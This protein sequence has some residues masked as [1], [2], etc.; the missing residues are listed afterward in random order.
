[1]K[2]KVQERA[3]TAIQLVFIGIWIANLKYTDSYFSVYAL[4]CVAAVIGLWERYTYSEI[5]LATSRGTEIAVMILSAFF[6]LAVVLANHNIFHRLR[7]MSDISMETNEFM[8]KFDAVCTWVGGVFVG[9]NILSY[10]LRHFPSEI[11]SDYTSR[12][13]SERNKPG[14]FFSCVFGSI[15]L[16]NLI[17]LF[18]VTYPGSVSGDSIWQIKQIASGAYVNNHPFWHT[19]IIKFFM[20]IGYAL[21]GD[22][23]AA[24]AT[25]SAGQIFIMAACFAYAMV[26]L[27]QMGIPNF[28]LSIAYAMYAFLP[29]N[30]TYS[31]TMWKDVLFGG[32]MLLSV[33]SA[34]RIIRK[35]G[36]HKG[37]DYMLFFIGGI[38]SCTLRTNGWVSML[39]AALFM[40][41][42][43]WKKEKVLAFTL[44]GVL[45][46]GWIMVGPAFTWL[47]VGKTD[48][49]EAFS[50]PLQ[51]VSR[52]IAKGREL[53]DEEVELLSQIVDLEEIAEIYDESVSDKIKDA[54]RSKDRAYFDEH[55]GEYASLWIQLGMRYPGD[56]LEAWIELTKGFW[57]GGYDY[58]IYAEYVKENP[59]GIY[60]KQQTNLIHKLV[61][62][63]FTFSREAVFFE[64]LQ[65][66]GLHVWL[67]IMLYFL[68][69][70]H[71]RP[72]TVLFVPCFIIIL[73]LWLGAPVYSQ[74]R[75]V[76][77]IFTAYPLLLPV[78]LHSP[79]TTLE[80][81]N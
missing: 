80:N 51:Q 8:N 43:L 53:T 4:C 55:L 72:E 60:M 12:K 77:P 16:I 76:Y 19:M 44:V 46:A 9:S 73:G 67:M 22:A 63:Y 71:K 28:W 7:D 36:K 75:Y 30:I 52:V 58:Y 45:F 10:L 3:V 64:P 50:V 54:V 61:K 25:Y 68:C 34:L 37:L 20:Q 6:S 27:Y 57:N 26:T 65:S 66:I 42:M 38:G 49:S 59:F 14:R 70:V 31:A 32:A 11:S 29:H 23:N 13:V 47:N 35:V 17:Y 21:F 18:F 40:I 5:P 78:A 62:A 74:F 1:M 33:I 81:R 15:C 79:E 69:A 48:V 41:P 56:Y 39:I 2:K 24:A